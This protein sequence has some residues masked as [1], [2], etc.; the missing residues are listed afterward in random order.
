M[1]IGYAKNAKFEYTR[2]GGKPLVKLPAYNEDG[3]VEWKWD[4]HYSSALE[5]RCKLERECYVGAVTLPLTEKARVAGVK[6]YADGRIVGRFSAGTGRVC[7]GEITVAVGVTAESLIIRIENTG[8]FVVGFY[9]PRISVCYDDEKPL[10]WPIPKKAS[11][12]ERSVRISAIDGGKNEDAKYAADFLKERLSERFG[13]CF[14]EDGVKVKLALSK[15]KA[16]EGERY[17]VSV[18]EDG[19]TLTAGSRLTLLYA[20]YALLSLGDDGAFRIAK[21]DT[22]P[23]KEWRGY[24]MGLPKVENLEFAR[25]LFRDI[26]L[27]LGYNT[28]F[29]QIIGAMEF[30]RHPE[31]TEAWIRENKRMDAL[32]KQFAH[33]Y[34]GCEGE[35]IPKAAVKE[36]MD[37]AHELGFEIVPEVQSLGHVQWIT[38]SHPEIAEV[39]K[40]DRVVDDTTNEDERPDIQYHH[41]YCPSNEK[42]YE[43]LF[44]VMDEIIEVTRPQRYVHIGHDEVYYMGL[45]EKCKDTPH[46]VLFARDV[47]RIY[48]HLKELGYGTMMWSDMIQPV[49]KYQTPGAIKMLPKDILMLDFIWYFHLDKDIEENLFPEGYKVLAGNLYSSHYPR[50]HKRMNVPEMHGGEVSSWCEVNE[51]R[52]GKKGKFWD[53]TYTAEMLWNPENYHDDMRTVFSHIISKHIQP[54]QRDIIRGKYNRLGWREKAFTLPKGENAGIPR[55]L[56]EAFPRAI[57]ADGAT[58]KV[59]GKYERLVIEHTALEVEKRVPWTELKLSG[60]YTVR[61]EDGEE[62]IAR[63]EYAGSVLCYNS[64]YGDPLPEGVHRHTGYVGTWFSNPV[65]EG[66]TEYGEDMLV[67]G[68]VVENPHPEK[69][70]AE[71]SYKAAETDISVV[72]LCGVKGLNRIS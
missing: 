62:F 70:I 60:E 45:C 2:V 67:M 25:R 65:Y 32:G 55:D 29:V 7:G 24:H 15:A 54:V 23:S 19:I 40:S 71:I 69:K 44:D 66:K 17:T 33:R 31:I 9:E 39:V 30:E 56:R 26:L 58:V 52:M 13:E 10:I 3:S 28:I 41:C 34:M 46:D 53:L 42:S 47:N 22:T 63:A 16:Y 64:R 11:Y 49:T 50:Y 12:G 1:Y 59:G 4:D 37:Y 18:S 36:L 51:Y 21:I 43:I 8:A 72:V 27:P 61:Y 5:I 6:V 57:I 68:Y 20:V 14:C 38:T 48:N 35:S